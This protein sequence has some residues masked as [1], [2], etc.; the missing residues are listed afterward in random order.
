MDGEEELTY[1]GQRLIRIRKQMREQD[2][3]R[4]R[5]PDPNYDP[6][7]EI[8]IAYVWRE[9][10]WIPITWMRGSPTP[11]RIKRLRDKHT[12]RRSRAT[13]GRIG[14][15]EVLRLVSLRVAA[16]MKGAGAPPLE[17]PPS[18]KV[19]LKGRLRRRKK[20]DPYRRNAGRRK[21]TYETTYL[22]RVKNRRARVAGKLPRCDWTSSGN[23]CPFRA[24]WKVGYMDDKKKFGRKRVV[25]NRCTKHAWNDEYFPATARQVVCIERK[26]KKVVA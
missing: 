23:R 15:R 21:T 9:D 25:K 12:R 8:F 13:R 6:A 3:A 19:L 4:F 14:R 18:P 7:K 17:R 5:D 24:F 10:E 2:K 11:T 1:E 16:R 20:K 22:D 26:P